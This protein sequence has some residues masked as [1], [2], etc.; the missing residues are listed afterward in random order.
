MFI[1]ANA[2][3]RQA[4]EMQEHLNLVDQQITEL[5]EFKETLGALKD[6]KEKEAII[7]LGK[8]VHIKSG[9]TDEKLF[10]EVGAGV[11]VRKTPEE[12][13]EVIQDQLLKLREMRIQFTVQIEQNQ[14]QLQTLISQL[15]S[16]QAESA[17]KAK[18]G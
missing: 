15:E 11:V 7:S 17:E 9:L 8:G 6:T 10:V 1:Q 12:T 4:Q 14:I 18:K 13:E 3:Q 16:Q 2:L 5:D